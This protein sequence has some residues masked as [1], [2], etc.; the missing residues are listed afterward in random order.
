ME[1]LFLLGLPAAGAVLSTYAAR[2]SERARDI[3]YRAETGAV[4]A[5]AL[6][7][8][9][10]ALRG[11]SI[12]AVL[13][14]I[15]GM[16]LTFCLD[17][18]RG[19]YVLITSF[20]W[21][22]TGLLSE[23]YF[24]VY[25]N[26]TRYYLFNQITFMATLGI[27][28]SNDLYTT[29]IFFEIMSLSSYPWVAHDETAEAL[30]A[31]RTYLVIAVFGGMVTLMGLFL[32]WHY[33]GSLSF[34]A[35]SAA[36]GRPEMTVPAA[37]IL[38]GFAA[39]AGLFPLYVWLPKAHPVA[40]APSSALLSGV[41]TK[42]GVFGILVISFRLMCGV[43]A[44]GNT[45]L[46][47]G[48]LTMLLGALLA[49]FSSNLKRVLACSSMSQ[50]GYITVG[51]AMTVLLG[52]E[53][54]VPESGALMH[55]VNHSL[56]KLT[57][58]MAAGVIYMNL[59]KL[60]LN[61]IRGFG[62]GKRLLHFAFLCGSLGLAGVPGF[63]GYLGKT[64]IH[65]GI[66]EY[67]H[68]AGGFGIYNICE[69][70]F[71]FAAGITTAY[72]LKLYIALFWEKHPERQAEFD[73]KNSSYMNTRSAFALTAAAVLI[74]VLGFVP[75]LLETCAQISE[76]FTGIEGVSGI[77]YFSFA[78]LKGGAVSLLI[79]TAVYFSVVR[80][81]LKRPDRG[82]ISVGVHIDLAHSGPVVLFLKGV[83]ILCS[84]FDH[85]LENRCVLFRLPKAAGIVSDGLDHVIE[86][87]FAEEIVPKAAYR[88]FD[89][90]NGAVDAFVCF[91]KK[92]LFHRN[93]PGGLYKKHSAY[94]HFAYIAGHI[95]DAFAFLLNITFYRSHPIEVDF[96][97]VL[98]ARV[99]DTDTEYGRVTRSVSY[100]LL[101]FSA[102][103][104]A[105]LFYL[106]VVR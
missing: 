86:N 36:A 52:R 25:R 85:A 8:F 22:M 51:I 47:L 83:D 12:T 75:A 79:G 43:R 55:M 32:A 88:I 18:F 84:L 41:L 77:A 29:F 87:R 62:R 9:A 53:G 28:L 5:L 78:N 38:V 49:L 73:A 98:A 60:E 56:L 94:Y 15:C 54:S 97:Y 95:L 34:D 16:D 27:F 104:L 57:L 42:T 40:P 67:A 24:R 35:F 66:L 45:M 4:L 61:D 50:I 26:R 46:F 63:N 44:F 90:L 93:T 76:G 2:R 3:I 72:M 10:G 58:F 89:T 21:F 71:L 64:L 30:S 13:P 23:E 6:F 1:I 31:A 7:F 80:T 74:P 37:L 103:L 19:L 69:W 96:T 91:M 17:G 20:M 70:I 33:M 101:L 106:L 11:Q 14:G 92:T 102:G 99:Y 48:L 82:Y 105:I 59:H 68:E 81:C 65:E 100:A 39:K